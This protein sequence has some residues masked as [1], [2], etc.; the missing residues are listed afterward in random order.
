MGKPIKKDAV[1]LNTVPKG[2]VIPKENLSEAGIKSQGPQRQTV[3]YGKDNHGK[4][5][6]SLVMFPALC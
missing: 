1:G 6:G 5:Y 4:K 2:G 3:A